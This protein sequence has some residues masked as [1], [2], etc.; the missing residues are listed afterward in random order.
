[1]ATTDLRINETTNW[2]KEAAVTRSRVATISIVLVL[3]CIMVAPIWMVKY[4]PLIDYP[5]HLARTFI[6]AHLH[7]PQFQYTRFYAVSWNLYPYLAMD[8]FLLL[9][10]Q[11]MNVTIAGKILLSLTALGVPAGAWAFLRRAN[12]GNEALAVFA[13]LI[14]YNALFL[15][16]LTNTYLSLALCFFCLA[17]WLKYTAQPRWSHWVLL[18]G[19]ITALYFTHL[20]GF[21]VAGLVVTGFAALSRLPLRRWLWSWALFVPGAACYGW[22][23]FTSTANWS[24]E[25]NFARFSQKVIGLIDPIR[26]YSNWLDIVTAAIILAAFGFAWLRTRKL[27]WDPRWAVLAG[28]LLF[29]YFLSPAMYGDGWDADKRILPFVLVIALA[30]PRVGKQLRWLVVVG[31][32]LFCVRVTNVAANFVA[33]QPRLQAIERSFSFIPQ[34]VRMLPVVE[35]NH[36]RD[37]RKP[38]LHFWA[39]GVIER[40]W[41]SPYI[42]T[43]KNVHA[44]RRTY[45]PYVPDVWGSSRW[46]RKQPDFERVRNDYDYVWAYRVPQFAAGFSDIG[47]LVYQDGD[48]AVYRI[49]R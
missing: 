36:D 46:G 18:S 48:I 5:D 35:V 22:L 27:G 24:H 42:F 25:M 28:V 19:L 9:L 38:Y 43:A 44:L 30:V 20:L 40:G 1:M 11:V 41:F 21:A 31:L 2:P 49:T 29:L 6:T 12:P 39:Y 23:R 14:P 4:P 26:G 15:E 33:E 47:S 37:I 13:L 45:Y 16:G 32:V 34:H 8:L 3:G 7:D 17:L 10:Q